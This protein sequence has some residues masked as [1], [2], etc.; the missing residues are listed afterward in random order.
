MDFEKRVSLFAVA[1]EGMDYT[2]W[3]RI[4]QGIEDRL[5]VVQRKAMLSNAEE[6]EKHFRKDHN[7][8]IGIDIDQRKKQK[9]MD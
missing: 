7:I 5:Y 2:E 8:Q 3:S 6:L 1:C 4:K 9:Q